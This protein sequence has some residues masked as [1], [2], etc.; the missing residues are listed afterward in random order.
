MNQELNEFENQKEIQADNSI[1]SVHDKMTI[2][3]LEKL[4][5]S[6]NNAA[7]EKEVAESDPHNVA[8]ALIELSEEKILIFFKSLPSDISADV[9]TCLSQDDKEKVARAFSSEELQKLLEEMSTDNIV[10][11]LDDLPANLVTKVLR[12][13]SSEDRKRI[14]AYLK[15]KD[16][17]AGTL[18]TPEYLAIKDSYTVEETIQKIRQVGKDLETIWRIFVVDNTRRLIGS[19]RLDHLLE[20]DANDV[21]KSV[22][23]YNNL[24]VK[25]DTDEEVVIKTFRKYDISIL[26]VTDNNGRMVGIITFDD[27]MDVAEEE[28]TE[29]IQISAAIV[30]NDKPYL[31]TSVLKLVKS[32]APWILF[33]LV[34]NTFTSMVL[35]YLNAPLA[36]IP[37]LTAFLPA[38]MGTNGNAS[39]QTCTVITRE[40]AL[41]NISPKTYWKTVLK[42][43]KAS[44]VTS[45]IMAVFSFVWVLIE[46][47]SGI[48]SLTAT[49]TNVISNLYNGNQHVL[50]V[51]VAFVISLTFFVVIVIAKFLGVS[52][53]MLAKKIH[54]DPAVMSQPLISNILDIISICVYFAFVVLIIRGV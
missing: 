37:L 2:S 53:P 31:K 38:I 8:D 1:A 41:D 12:Y 40:L 17:S 42:E 27:V 10:D 18:M 16:D 9:F 15:F 44:V 19:I 6:H 46:L 28:N 20:A 35:S 52:L 25:V 34:L 23:D 5:D 30:P 54:L 50:F 29:D 22:M 14:S 47:Y 26:P 33:L 4:L 21:I 45:C 39:D 7:L 36:V 43:F 48:I 3:Q 24:A 51:S 32:Y 13:T 11:F 49:D